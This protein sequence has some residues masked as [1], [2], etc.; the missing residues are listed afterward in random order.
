[1]ADILEPHANV[2]PQGMRKMKDM[3]DGSHAPEFAP[4]PGEGHLGEI[5]GNL[6]TIA[7]TPTIQ[8]AAYIAGDVVG[9]KNALAN[10]ARVAGGSGYITG[11]RI[12]SKADVTAPID[13]LLFRADPT[14]TTWTENGAVAVHA[15]DL[16]ALVGA[17]QVFNWFDLGTPVVGV[18]ECRIP[19]DIA[20][21]TSLHF[22]L[23]MRGGVTFASTS[24]LVV[25][26]SVDR[27]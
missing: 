5:G 24:D 15:D 22:A 25:E 20:S 9:G 3:G 11:V 17:V 18:A 4:A 7:V 16:A 6:L 27:N 19:Y 14:N 21:G 13:V 12:T 26:V 2:R 1:M 23:V 10:A 8:A